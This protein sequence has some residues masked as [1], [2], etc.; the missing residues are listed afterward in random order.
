MAVLK[1]STPAPKKSGAKVTL[2]FTEKELGSLASEYADISAQIKALE[3]RKKVLSDKI[4]QGAEQLGVKDDKGSH[5]LETSN[6]FVLG[7]VASKSMK[8][9][10][11]KAVPVLKEMGLKGCVNRVVSE[12][13]NEPE[14]ERAVASGKITLEE[15]EQFTTVST[16]YKVSVTKKEE[17][18][19]VEQSTVKVAARK[20]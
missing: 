19:V 1:K 16:S 11:E 2:M 13:V 7:K 14:L 8:I 12:T 3:E 18:P 4:K 15:V 10:H 5:Y 9:D 6:G 20:K 17:M